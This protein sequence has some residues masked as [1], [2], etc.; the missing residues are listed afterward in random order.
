MCEDFF[1]EI[2]TQ[3]KAKNISD[4]FYNQLDKMKFQDKHKYK[5]IKEQWEYAYNKVSSIN[6]LVK[7]TN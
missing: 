2:Y 4:Q 3:I 7:E 1:Y 5:T 6:T